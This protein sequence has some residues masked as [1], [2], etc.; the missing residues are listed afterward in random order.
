MKVTSGILGTHPGARL[1]WSTLLVSMVLGIALTLLL[2]PGSVRADGPYDFLVPIV[3]EEGRTPPKQVLGNGAGIRQA[4][5]TPSALVSNITETPVNTA[6]GVDFSSDYAQAFTTGSNSQGYKLTSIEIHMGA[7]AAAPS[8][9]AA[10]H[11]SLGTSPSALVTNG[12]LNNPTH[13]TTFTEVEFSASGNGIDLDAN[14]TY[15]LVFDVTGANTDTKFTV[16]TSDAQTGTGWSIWNTRLAR[17]HSATAWPT[18]NPAPNVFRFKVNGYANVKPVLTSAEVNETTLVLTF[19]NDLN[20]A[21]RTAAREFGIRFGG[22]ALQRATAIAISGRQVTL[23]VPEV[24]S[25]QVVTVSYTKPTSNPLKG[26]NGEDADAFSDYDVKVNTGPAY[27]RLPE[28]GKVRDALYFT[29]TNA[30]GEEESVEARAYSADRETILDYFEDECRRTGQANR[31]GSAGSCASHKLY[32]R[33]SNCASE[34][35]VGRQ[36][37]SVLANICPDQRSW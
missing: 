20:T 32:V 15:W 17:T 2:G 16:T 9:T 13:P 4:I 1:I 22:G 14:T 23:T 26:A 11:A 8:Y 7:T 24:R 5:P 28:S 34:D 18:T 27:G 12:T 36:S 3:L 37:S 30:D 19:S 31:F 35:W 33:Q 6:D 29:Y 21:S 10:I 25:G